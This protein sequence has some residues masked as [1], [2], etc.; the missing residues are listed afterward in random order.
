MNPDAG[1]PREGVGGVELDL[2]VI[3]AGRCKWGL[4]L[5]AKPRNPLNQNGTLKYPNG[6]ERRTKVQNE[7]SS[8]TRQFKF[9]VPL[10][11]RWA[12]LFAS[13]S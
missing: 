7:C 4:E 6:T 13:V 2:K 11:G 1:K 10:L 12:H 3:M 9:G 5:E 8:V